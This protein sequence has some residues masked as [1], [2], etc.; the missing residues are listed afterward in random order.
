M[1]RS[2]GYS[3]RS[4]F[5][6]EHF[7][8]SNLRPIRKIQT[9]AQDSLFQ[10]AIHIAPALGYYV[11][12][13]LGFWYIY[14]AFRRGMK[15]LLFTLQIQQGGV[16]ISANPWAAPY[17]VLC[18][19]QINLHIRCA[20]CFFRV[21]AWGSVLARARASPQARARRCAIRPT[22]HMQ[23]HGARAANM[24]AHA[25]PRRGAAHAR[26]RPCPARSARRPY[27]QRNTLLH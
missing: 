27:A 19:G 9:D 2:P 11:E 23:A 17:K 8:S 26:R 24:Y 25:P 7:L 22:A 21:L 16:L 3:S 12:K 18:S 6:I 5:L 10:A 15:Y 14:A 20:S 4:I 13:E 1:P